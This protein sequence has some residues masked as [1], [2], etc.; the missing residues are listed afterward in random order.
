MSTLARVRSRFSN[1]GELARGS[2]VALGIQVLALSIGYISQVVLVKVLGSAEYGKFTY[3]MALA[4]ALAIVAGLGFTVS[5]LRFVSQYTATGGHE[6]ARQF[7]AFAVRN[8]GVVALVMLLLGGVLMILVRH[9]ANLVL[10][11]WSFGFA[12]VLM[13]LFAL[14]A[15]NAEFIRAV[16][17]VFAAYFPTR[18]LQSAVLLVGGLVAYFLGWHI[19]SLYYIVLISVVMLLILFFQITLIH[20]FVGHYS[21]AANQ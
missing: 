14:T 18:V 20:R 6:K 3:I 17:K 13:P 7:I 10:P 12:L 4:N 15:L 16:G 5:G 21:L 9:Y 1:L 8:V 2:V 11:W 19:T